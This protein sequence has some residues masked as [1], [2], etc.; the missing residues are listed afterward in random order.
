MNIHYHVT[1]TRHILIVTL[2]NI[3][4]Q[5]IRLV[6]S[7][8]VGWTEGQAHS[9]FFRVLH[10]VTAG[11]G[12]DGLAV[13]SPGTVSET[14]EDGACKLRQV[15]VSGRFAFDFVMTFDLECR[16]MTFETSGIRSV[17]QGYRGMQEIYIEKVFYGFCRPRWSSG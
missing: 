2:F 7:M 5:Y 16:I 14:Q 11:K 1:I 15:S 13:R 17:W 4:F 3:V 9:A 8:T 6:G 12:S 10:N